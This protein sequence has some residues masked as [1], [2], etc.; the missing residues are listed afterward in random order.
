MLASP[1]TK[2]PVPAREQG[3]RA[4]SQISFSSNEESDTSL[5]ALQADEPYG[6][7]YTT[8]CT[9]ASHAFAGGPR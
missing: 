4:E 8:A 2:S 3:H 1:E 6:G 7:G 9:I 5:I